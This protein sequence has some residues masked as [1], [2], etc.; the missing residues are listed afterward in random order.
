MHNYYYDIV[1]MQNY[2]ISPMVGFCDVLYIKLCIKHANIYINSSPEKH[3]CMV[4]F[5]VFSRGLP[6]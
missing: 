1:C 3:K 6:L 4:G 5:S 2:V